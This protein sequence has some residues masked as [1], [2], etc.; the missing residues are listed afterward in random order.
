MLAKNKDA[1]GPGSEDGSKGGDNII[2]QT[3]FNY[4]E[5]EPD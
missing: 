4:V 2:S 5:S 1:N 3:S